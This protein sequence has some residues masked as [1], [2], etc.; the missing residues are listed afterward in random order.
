MVVPAGGDEDV[1]VVGVELEGVDPHGVARLHVHVGARHQV[2]AV[3]LV[4]LE[5][6]DSDPH[7]IGQ[8]VQ[9]GG[10]G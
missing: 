4:R 9:K 6:L 1:L 8:G 5:Q 7:C 3:T 2:G 10:A